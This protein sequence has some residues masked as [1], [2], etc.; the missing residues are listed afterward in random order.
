MYIRYSSMSVYGHYINKGDEETVK[1][2]EL[3]F[4]L[5]DDE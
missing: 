2:F 3:L 4:V 5:R 1:T